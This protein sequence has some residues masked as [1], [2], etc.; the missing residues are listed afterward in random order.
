MDFVKKVI[1]I[2]D[3][4]IR[5]MKMHDQ[6]KESMNKLVK[7]VKK[8]RKTYEYNEIRLVITG[9]LFHQK[10]TVSNEQFVLAHTFLKTCLKFCP[11]VLIAG[12][13]DLLENNSDRLDSITP[14]V[15]VLDDP[16]LKYYKES[17]CY[18]DNNIVWCVYSVLDKNVPPDIKSARID[19]GNDKKY[20]GLF[21]GPLIGSTTDVGYVFEHGISTK[22][23]D[24]CDAVMLGD[25][26]KQSEFKNGD[27][28]LVYSSSLTQ[29]NYGE[30]IEN[31]GYI[32][33]DIETLNYEFVKIE[34]SHKLYKFEINGL[35]DIESGN[36]K[37]VNK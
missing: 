24:G 36:E 15:T 12:N 30:S 31:H 19:H 23:F 22:Y 27:A 11:V 1:H 8:L 13:H 37:H 26:H 9:D 29:Q 35:S 28:P 2:S 21:H 34:N 25:I 7:D 3:V 4:H 10:I 33:W 32:L 18:L 5:N 16:N 20:I 14:I 6:V 17:K